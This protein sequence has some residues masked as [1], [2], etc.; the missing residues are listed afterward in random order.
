MQ[1]PQKLPA[2]GR[3]CHNGD[4][5]W[6]SLPAHATPDT[7]SCVWLLWPPPPGQLL[8]GR[9]WGW[10][11]N[12][13]GLPRWRGNH[14]PQSLAV[15]NHGEVFERPASYPTINLILNTSQARRDLFEITEHQLPF[16]QI[17]PEKTKRVLQEK[18]RN[19]IKACQHC[20]FRRDLLRFA[21]VSTRESKKKIK[22]KMLLRQQQR[23]RFS[24][25]AV[26]DIR[27]RTSAK[28]PLKHFCA[29]LGLG[30]VDY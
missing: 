29:F 23:S 15:T 7:L 4:G 22:R 25:P 12:S 24:F 11:L 26:A 14:P 9:H 17:K 27:R 3:H 2:G 20:K 1:Q 21:L 5:V 16:P 19:K 30:L 10:A 28:G 18:I 6:V 13:W 8:W